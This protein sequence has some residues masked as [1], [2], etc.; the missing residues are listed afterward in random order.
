VFYY[1]KDYDITDDVQ[2]RLNDRMPT[3]KVV[4]PKVSAQDDAAAA[5]SGNQGSSDQ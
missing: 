1:S 3:L 4:I 2:S 5:A